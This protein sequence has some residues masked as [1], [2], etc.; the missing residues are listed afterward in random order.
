LHESWRA[1]A[2]LSDAFPVKGVIDDWAAWLRGEE[3]EDAVVTRI[4]R[5]THTGR[6]CGAPAFLA[7][8]ESLLHRDLL[9]SKR[10]RKRKQVRDVEE[11]IN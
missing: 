4:R 7:G 5:Q 9:P 3:D 10:G 1:D 11:G 6:P 8:L 2:L